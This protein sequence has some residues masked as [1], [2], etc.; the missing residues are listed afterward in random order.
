MGG[1]GGSP[2][3]ALGSGRHVR[4]TLCDSLRL[5]QGSPRL[6]AAR[7]RCRC[8]RATSP[9]RRSSGGRCPTQAV[10][11]HQPGS[12]AAL[13]GHAGP[14][15]GGANPCQCQPSKAECRAAGSVHG[16]S[17]QRRCGSA[18]PGSGSGPAA[19][20]QRLLCAKLGVHE[21]DLSRQAAPGGSCPGR[22]R[23]TRGM[24]RAAAGAP[25]VRALEAGRHGLPQA[26]KAERKVGSFTRRLAACCKER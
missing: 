9:R 3:R 26:P 24:R 7:G 11:L 5:R 6:R 20:C 8:P 18:G 15:G 1:R 17:G 25:G 16:R 12:E 4:H 10:G 22:L 13:A 23:V 21:P 14:R 19:P 2:G